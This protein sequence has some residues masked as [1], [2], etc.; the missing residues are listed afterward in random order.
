MDPRWYVTDNNLSDF[1]LRLII[2]FRFKKMNIL[3]HV[4]CS[5]IEIAYELNKSTATVKKS[6][7]K[8]VELEF[9]YIENDVEE[10]FL[11]TKKHKRVIWT[12]DAYW[13]H[14][15]DKNKNIKLIEQYPNEAF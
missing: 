3:G 2:Y 4:V 7:D 15:Y 5:N 8:L 6:L 9:L 10:P 13:A 11:Y 14:E 1:E 12:F